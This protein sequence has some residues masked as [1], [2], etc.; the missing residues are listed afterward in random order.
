MGFASAWLESGSLFPELIN[1]AP[2]DELGMIVV[3]PAY[4]EPEI[5]Y[6]LDSLKNC[7]APGCKVEVIILINSPKGAAPESIKNNKTTFNDIESW[8]RRNN[9]LFFRLFAF[10]LEQPEIK[11]WGVGLARKSGMDEALRRFDRLGRPEGLIINLDADCTVAR[12]YFQA[13]EKD[14]LEN[15][16]KK[17]CSLYFEHPLSGN[18]YKSEVYRAVALY[19]L[20][21]RYYF[22][23]L[24]YTGFPDV[25]HTVGSAIAVKAISY[26]KAGGMN[27]RQAGE[28]FYF[29]QKLVPAGGYFNLYSTTVYPSPRVSARVPFGTGAAVS[30][31]VS[32]G[33]TGLTTYNPLAFS[34][35]KTFFSI[36]DNPLCFEDQPSENLFDQLPPSVRSFLGREEWKKKIEEISG[37]TSGHSSF[38]KR[39]FEWFNMFRVVKYLNYSHRGF[40]E[41]TEVVSA[42]VSLLEMAGFEGI[43]A[44]VE[45]LISY[46]REAEKRN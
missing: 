45:N 35:L 23:A 37:N 8:K 44:S 20:H 41:K 27:R 17:G 25:Y 11:G 36:L 2:S 33:D 16:T 42:A 32:S 34:D 1:E 15:R 6:L 4:D 38:R 5:T 24:K 46:L 22:Q 26:L 29:V 9:D 10:N 18:K 21:L 3:V 13:L 30:K 31:I 7:N 19:E 43:P 28:D 14:L 12:N 40:F 39:F